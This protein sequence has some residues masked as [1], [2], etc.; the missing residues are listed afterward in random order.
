MSISQA[1][2]QPFACSG[3]KRPDVVRYRQNDFFPHLL[4]FR[5][6]IPEWDRETGERIKKPPPP[7]LGDRREIVLCFHD[8]AIFKSN[9][10]KKAGWIQDGHQPILSKSEGTG[11]MVSGI[12]TVDG[13]LRVPGT[14][15]QDVPDL[16]TQPQGDAS[17]P[18]ESIQYMFY[19]KAREGYW[20][21]P[22]VVDQVRRRA[23]SLPVQ[24]VQTGHKS[25]VWASPPTAWTGGPSIWAV[26]WLP[27]AS[28][29]LL[30]GSTLRC[31]V[32]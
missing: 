16:G 7:R 14:P 24:T 8:E 27:T 26:C 19:G 12:L 11:L 2:L 25:P 4:S 15:V 30:V 5:P 22:D 9:D 18:L 31:L 10:G 3:H 20:T 6:R 23:H 28:L 29:P 17:G 1:D 21:G 13:M 32:C